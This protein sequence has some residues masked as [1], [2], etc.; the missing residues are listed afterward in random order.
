MQRALLGAFVLAC[1]GSAPAQPGPSA[2]VT[3]ADG[4]S[5]PL[6][7]WTFSYEY[8]AYA[9]GSSPALAPFARR[10]SNSLWCGKR[11][12]AVAGLGLEI[13][14]ETLERQREVNGQPA[15]VT[16]FVVRE[17]RLTGAD[18]TRSALKLEPPSREALVPGG[19]KGLVVAPRSLD[20]QGET[21]TGTR[22][23]YCLASYTSL[24]E[25]GADPAHRVTRVDFR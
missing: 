14:Y 16:L 11:S 7:P 3:L 9:K 19:D 24:V 1:A 17:L 13:G 25:C 5:V 12:L 23:R 10:E 20:L 15:K 2:V 21:L 6:Q 8:L 18:G 22:T 4:T